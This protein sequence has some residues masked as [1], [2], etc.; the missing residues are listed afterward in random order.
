MRQTATRKIRR[1][2]ALLTQYKQTKKTQTGLLRLSELTS[3]TTDLSC[4]YQQLQQLIQRYFPADNLYIQVFTQPHT[5]AADHFYVDE[6]NCAPI[7]QQLDKNL[8]AFISAIGKPVLINHNTASILEQGDEISI[9]PFPTRDQQTKLVDVW[10]AAPLIIENITVGLVGIKGL[11]S[12][13]KKLVNDLQL[14]QFIALHISS[15]ILRNR[16][17]E[18]LKA[19]NNDIEDIIFARTQ[20]LQ[21]SNLDL[22][23][24]V[25]KRR[26]SEQQLYFA[27]HHDTLTKLP[28]RQG[29][30]TKPL[31]L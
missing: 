23:K 31:A 19:Y 29:K 16:A 17:N 18:R 5:R 8:V 7:D 21:K 2:K 14:I 4:F 28:N 10:L 30:I 1:L 13:N 3:S 22:R 12:Y 9:R 15:A 11:L 25:E 26:Q 20:L 27:A 6:L 24:Q